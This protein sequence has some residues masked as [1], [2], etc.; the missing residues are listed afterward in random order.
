ML[1]HKQISLIHL[2][3]AQLSLDDDV[4]RAILKQIGGVDSSKDLDR[5]G[6]EAVMKYFN[7]WGFRSTWIRRTYGH[8]HGMA[9]PGQVEYIH[10]LWQQYHGGNDEVA[11]NKWL[12][13]SF[14]IS[15]L[16]FV[17]RKI[18]GKAITA[19]KQMAKRPKQAEP[20][21]TP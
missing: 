13:H 7:A 17:D 2:A 8:R 14:K 4:Y 11:L 12:Q 6:F 5:L 19:L 21:Q 16:R 9:T 18:A 20:A 15:A 1:T 3:K 10:K